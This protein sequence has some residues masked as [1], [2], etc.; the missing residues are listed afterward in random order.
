MRDWRNKWGSVL[1]KEYS[2]AV[3]KKEWFPKGAIT[4]FT[5]EKQ[6][7]SFICYLYPKGGEVYMELLEY[8]LNI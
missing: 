1:T 7:G 8:A 4:E 6:Q 3:E 5:K 2:T